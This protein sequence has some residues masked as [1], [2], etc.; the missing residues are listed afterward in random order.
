MCPRVRRLVTLR[1]Q[2]LPQITVSVIVQHHVCGGDSV[3]YRAW[4]VISVR[5]GEAWIMWIGPCFVTF[6]C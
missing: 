1:R 2:V 5:A 3:S 6:E 4:P